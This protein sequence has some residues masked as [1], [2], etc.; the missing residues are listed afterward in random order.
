MKV[1]HHEINY[2]GHEKSETTVLLDMYLM[3]AIICLIVRGI[4]FA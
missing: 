2:F 3:Y 1:I 4:L